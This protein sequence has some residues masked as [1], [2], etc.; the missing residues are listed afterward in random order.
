MIFSIF[1]QQD[2]FLV[3]LRP[4]FASEWQYLYRVIVACIVFVKH[5]GT[6]GYL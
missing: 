5:S 3:D 2:Y 1:H 4:E 6:D